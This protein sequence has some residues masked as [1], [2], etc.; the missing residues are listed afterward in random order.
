MT[1]MTRS[2]AMGIAAMAWCLG[3]YDGFSVP[4]QVR[5]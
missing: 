1:E 3:M 5:S 4:G 2:V